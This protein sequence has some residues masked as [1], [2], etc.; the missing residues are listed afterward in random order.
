MAM[1]ASGADIQSVLKGL[2][3][4]KT[5]EEAPPVSPHPTALEGLAEALAIRREALAPE[6]SSDSDESESESTQF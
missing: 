5:P 6:E 4:L 1:A 3:K 2:R